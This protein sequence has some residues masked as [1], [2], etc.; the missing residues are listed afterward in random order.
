MKKVAIIQARMSST[1]LP[2]KVLLPLGDR[3]VLGQV[4]RRVKACPKVD[5]IVIATTPSADDDQIVAEASRN[6]TECF[7]GSLTDVLARYHGAAL[8]VKAGTVIRVTSDCP[9]F[10]PV[11]LSEM[12]DEFERDAGQVDY[13]SNT[14]ARTYPRGLDA[15]I[16][17]FAALDEAFRSATLPWDREHVTPY[18]YGHPE[19]FR[20]K[21]HA[22]PADH[23]AHRW[24]LDTPEDYQL[25]QA[26]YRNLDKCGD[27]FSTAQVLDLLAQNP[28]LARINAHI[29]Q[30]KPRE[31]NDRVRDPF[32]G[33]GD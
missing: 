28:A 33:R 7:R 31:S 8:C 3:T 16:F 23:S 10:D 24:T 21:N 29:E 27:L 2:G 18:I 25:I 26:V 6:Q 11:V 32:R 19:Q 22:G 20:L 13:L 5:Q 9:L 12:L 1:R 17:T 15:E 4:I 14:L 30:K